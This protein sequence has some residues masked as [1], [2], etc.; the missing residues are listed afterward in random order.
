MK[1]ILKLL[2]QENA[3]KMLLIVKSLLLNQNTML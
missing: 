1:Q 3:T 2:Q